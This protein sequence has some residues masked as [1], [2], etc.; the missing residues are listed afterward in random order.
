VLA[1][2]A[3]SELAKKGLLINGLAAASRER[4]QR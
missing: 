3:F 2:E 4:T 1:D